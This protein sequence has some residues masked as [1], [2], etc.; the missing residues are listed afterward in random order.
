MRPC[1]VASSKLPVQPGRKRRKNDT[2]DA[3][4]LARLHRVDELT[5]IWIPDAVH[6]A[7]QDLVR[8]RR[9]ASH[10]VRKARQRISCFL[11]K[12]GQHYERKK[13]GHR[14]RVRLRSFRGHTADGPPHGRSISRVCVG[15]LPKA[16]DTQ[17]SDL[18]QEDFDKPTTPSGTI[19]TGTSAHSTPYLFLQLNSKLA[20]RSYRRVIC[21]A[22]T[23]RR[24]ASATTRFLNSTLQ[25]QRDALGFP[26]MT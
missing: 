24:V 19:S 8:A 15:P 22:E 3:I 4:G 23:S 17:S 2:N 25:R 21:A 13:W 5:C 16:A 14:H 18:L 1:V 7:M 10:Q 11:L 6:E 12:H 26:A 9:T 20:F